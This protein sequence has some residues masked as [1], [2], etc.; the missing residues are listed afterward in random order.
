MR[1]ARQLGG[2][3]KRE[4]YDQLPGDFGAPAFDTR[5]LSRAI[6]N[7][8]HNGYTHVDSTVALLA[9]TDGTDLLLHVDD[10]GSGIEPALRDKA[11]EP[12]TRLDT[13]RNRS[14][15]GYGLGLAL[16]SRIVEWHQGRVTMSESSW[17][18]RDLPFA[19]REKDRLNVNA[20]GDRE[21]LRMKKESK[22]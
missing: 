21:P 20:P 22:R 2:A 13:S 10:D 8:L 9:A 7:L 6:A 12:F 18:E 19:G 5:Y 3:I 16:V 14:S 1:D 15:G 11:F 4:L 17:A